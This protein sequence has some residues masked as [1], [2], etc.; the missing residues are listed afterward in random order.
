MIRRMLGL[1][2]AAALAAAPAAAKT[3]IKLGTF[4]PAGSTYHD[5]LMDLRQ[6]WAR[7]SRG[8]IE[9]RIY[10]GGVTGSE[11]DMIRKMRIGQ[12]QAATITSGGLP[13]IDPAFRAF[14]V[15]LMF[16]STDELHF[17]LDEMRPR[18]DGILLEHGFRAL[19]WAD[20]G[21]LYFF[22]RRPVRTPDDLRPQRLFVW[23]GAAPLVE[24]WREGGFRP[25]QLSATDIH[26]A[27]QS[28]MLEAIATPPVIAL[29]NQWFAQVPH[30][31]TLKW[32]PLMA[33]LVVSERA[34]SKIPEELRPL[35]K[36]AAGRAALRM[37]ADIRD[38][39]GEAIAVM[40]KHG[41]AVHEVSA[42]DTELW[43]RD[44]GRFFDPLIGGYIDAD[45]VREIRGRLDAYRAGY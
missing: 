11:G 30:M 26:T 2:L 27:L 7:I 18:L 20:A 25:E 38:I 44:V 42:A 19:G 24:A 23:A 37:R 35:L 31:S 3:V 45:M 36:D 39:T 33:T 4:A 21:W 6:D 41:L 29:S 17:I 32:A 34:W 40:K 14:Q 10:A 8:Q 15:P 13:D 1:V 28:R 22:T 43:R 9:L 12:L 16:E 5:V